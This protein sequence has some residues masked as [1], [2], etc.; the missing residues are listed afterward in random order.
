MTSTTTTTPERAA[1]DHLRARAVAGEH[2]P[3]TELMHALEAAITAD[4]KAEHAAAIDTARAKHKADEAAEIKRKRKAGE[5]KL[6]ELVTALVEAQEIRAQ[7]HTAMTTAIREYDRTATAQNQ[8]VY[9]LRDALTEAGYPTAQPRRGAES[10]HVHPERHPNGN[11]WVVFDGH[12]YGTAETARN[13][14]PR[15]YH[16]LRAA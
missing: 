10:A 15:F 12:T 11:G 8:A 16:H 2:V 7:A 1:Y 6:G 13:A 14:I 9:A 5:K 3:E 4:K